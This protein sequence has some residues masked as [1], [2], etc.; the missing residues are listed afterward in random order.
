M[1]T[2]TAASVDDTYEFTVISGGTLPDNEDDIVIEWRSE[3]GSGTIELEGNDKTGSQIIV[4]VDG[5]TLTFDGGTLVNGDVFMSPRMKM[6]KPLADAMEMPCRRLRTGTGP[7]NP[8]PM[9][10]TEMQA[11]LTASVTKNN[12]VLFDTHDDYCAIENVTCS[13]SHNIDEENF[14]IT[15]LNYSALEFEA[16]GLEFV[17]TTDAITGLSS[18]SVNNP[19]G[20][21][22]AIIP[23]GG[24]DAGFQIDLDGDGIGIL[25]IPL[26]SLFQVTDISAWI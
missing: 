18:W 9:S 10:L 4:E 21:T 25:K 2:G 26:S 12:T 6:V 24:N 19:T 16:E 7:L 5:M 22:I 1:V 23:T 11:V 15:V 3:T 20:H 14:E 8:L 17:R 13:G